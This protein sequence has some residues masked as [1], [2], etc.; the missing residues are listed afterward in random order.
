MLDDLSDVDNILQND[1]CKIFPQEAIILF[2]N[3][4]I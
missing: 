2:L 1:V 4:N 3:S